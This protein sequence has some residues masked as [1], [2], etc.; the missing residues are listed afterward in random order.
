M[1]M[2][3]LH[4]KGDQELFSFLTD[5]IATE[6]KTMKDG[7]V[8]NTLE[9][10]AV[11]AEQSELILTKKFHD[12]EIEITLNVNHTVDADDG[13][14]ERAGEDQSEMRSRPN[15]EIDIKKGNQTL[16]FS[17]SYIRDTPV[18][19]SQDDYTDNFIIDEIALYEGEWKEQVYA[20]AGDI[21]DGYLYDLFMNLLEER[22]IS[23][24]FTDKL[25]DFCTDYEHQLYVSLLTRLQT[26]VGQKWSSKFGIY[27]WYKVDV[28][29]E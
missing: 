25:S 5:E 18:E 1:H 15:F 28:Y 6:R 29:L 27:I 13:G 3:N 20:V 14:E 11:K 23:N 9:G 12:E 16:S 7:P 4:T 17:C 2:S 24:E 8:G 19:A 10:F 22:G 21:L 26:F